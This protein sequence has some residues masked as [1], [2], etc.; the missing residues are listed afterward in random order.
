ME[1]KFEC[2]TANTHW[3]RKPLEV[4]S[5]IRKNVIA[6]LYELSNVNFRTMLDV[7]VP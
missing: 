5:N 3:I 6:A 2:Q 4:V 1:F 7:C